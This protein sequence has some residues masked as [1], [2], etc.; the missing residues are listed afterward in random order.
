MPQPQQSQSSSA[1]HAFPARPRTATT[2]GAALLGLLLVLL[3]QS[4]EA[5]AFSVSP[6]RVSSA[7]LSRGGAAAEVALRAAAASSSNNNHHLE[8]LPDL[9][10]VFDKIQQVSPLA[11][12]VMTGSH[13]AILDKLPWKTVE[14]RPDQTVHQIDKLDNFG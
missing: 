4:G 11:R 6:P 7:S 13:E 12:K 2:F 10:A 1:F 14:R 5:A 8:L 3:R 9:T